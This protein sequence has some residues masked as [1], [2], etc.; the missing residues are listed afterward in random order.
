MLLNQYEYEDILLFKEKVNELN[1][2]N[3]LSIVSWFN[4]NH[5]RL[6]AMDIVIE[7]YWDIVVKSISPNKEQTDAFLLTFRMFIQKNDRISIRQIS[8]I[9]EKLPNDMIEKQ[10]FN[11][12]H[13]D[14]N[15]Y[16]D[17]DSM[18]SENDRTWTNREIMYNILFGMRGHTERDKLENCKRWMASKIFAPYYMDAFI[19]SVEK[20]F[21][22]LLEIQKLNNSITKD[23]SLW[24]FMK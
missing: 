12:I 7:D 23:N 22:C 20:I 4:E 2:L 8:R 16:L 15:N 14:I 3:E 6:L 13:K 24:E 17:S 9:Y 19:S 11:K 1:E 21:N 10:S 18:L 5:K